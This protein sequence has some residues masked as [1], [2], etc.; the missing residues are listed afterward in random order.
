MAHRPLPRRRVTF[1]TGAFARMPPHQHPPSWVPVT[2]HGWIAA[3]AA[4]LVLAA[5]TI[6]GT[7][8][9][10][11]LVGTAEPDQVLAKGG[12]DVIFGLGGQGPHRRRPGQRPNPGRRDVRAERDAA[13][14]LHRR[15]RSLRRQRR[16]ARRRRRR[17]PARRAAATTTSTAARRPTRCRPTPATTRCTAAT[18]TT[19]STAGR[20]ST[21]SRRRRRR[22]DRDRA[23]TDRIDAGAGRR[24]DRHRDRQ[25]PDR[26][27]LGERPDRLRQ[28][29]RPDRSGFAGATRSNSGPGN[30]TIDARDGDTRRRSAAGPGA[31]R[32][33]ADRARPP[34]QLRARQRTYAL[35]PG[36]FAAPATRR[37]RVADRH[38]EVV[39]RR[40]GI[41]LH[42]AR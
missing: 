29:A 7:D 1:P 34:R 2:M 33:V 22:L 10:D 16:A 35:K 30:D 4:A 5:P 40:Q 3:A 18:A 25:R 38:R 15:R 42:H 13:G 36:T 6:E 28:R 20:A 27:W 31:I 8:L 21:R 32:C 11:F 19:R 41:R 9:T 37:R 23:G 12:D 17:R 26:R 14:E 39:Q 24:P